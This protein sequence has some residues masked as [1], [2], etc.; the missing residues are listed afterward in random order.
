[1]YVEVSKEMD[2]K[3]KNASKT[4]G[5]DEEQLVERALLLYLDALEK[6]VELKKELLAWDRMSDEDLANFEENLK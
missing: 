2:K 4:L 1:M 6:Q 5:F 3:L